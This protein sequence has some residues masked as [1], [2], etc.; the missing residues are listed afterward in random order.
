MG[1][2][3]GFLSKCLENPTINAVC[4]AV[5]GMVLTAVVNFLVRLDT[6]E[7]WEKFRAS[8]PRLAGL[9]VLMRAIG[10]D[11]AKLAKSIKM[12]LKGKK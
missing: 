3:I 11:P 8:H 7:S 6:P 9:V 5:A 4:L 12:I 1:S 10:V 2:I